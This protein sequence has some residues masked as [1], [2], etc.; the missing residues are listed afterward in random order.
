MGKR[1]TEVFPGL[2]LEAGTTALLEQATV[3]RITTTKRRDFLRIYLFSHRLIM[4]DTI[5]LLEREI[6]R[7]LFPGME[8]TVKIY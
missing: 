7:Q 5:F 2:R 6:G 1:F 3:E 4:K 8:M